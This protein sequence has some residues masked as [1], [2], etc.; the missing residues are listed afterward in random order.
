MLA[1]RFQVEQARNAREALERVSQLKPLV[2]VLG[3][4]GQSQ[5]LEPAKALREEV[6]RGTLIIGHGRFPYGHKAKDLPKEKVA[7]AYSMDDFVP[8]DLAGEDVG[9][10]IW[11]HVA[12]AIRSVPR[13]PGKPRKS[14]EE[15][16]TE[17]MTGDASLDSVR[18]VL[19]KP[20][21]PV[22]ELGEDSEPSWKDYLTAPVGD[23]LKRL[24]GG[25]KKD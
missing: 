6:G 21:L 14:T 22:T 5:G 7:S 13:P 15:T 24:F 4:K 23:T 3:L 11:S 10:V 2:I 19:T 25:K 12:D 8:R 18:K 20:I 16:W 17:L 9:K 1:G